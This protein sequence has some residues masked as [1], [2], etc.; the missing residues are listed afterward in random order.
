VDKQD[1]GLQTKYN[2]CDRFREQDGLHAGQGLVALDVNQKIFV[3]GLGDIIHE[4]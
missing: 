3:M 4:Q 1:K 2:Y